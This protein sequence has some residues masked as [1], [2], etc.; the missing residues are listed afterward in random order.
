MDSDQVLVGLLGSVER[1][2]LGWWGIAE[3]AVQPLGVVPVH[4]AEGG[5]LDLVDGAPRPLA[6]S[7]DQLRLVEP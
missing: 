5:Q 4:P 6:G 1:L 3:V 2:E 7:A